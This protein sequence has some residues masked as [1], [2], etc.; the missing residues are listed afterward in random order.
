MD[1]KNIAIIFAGGSGVRMGSGMPKQFLKINGQPIIIYTLEIFDDNPEIDDI[2]IACKED[3]IGTLERYISR[4]QIQKVRKIVPGGATG[5]DSIYNAL[6]AAREDNPADSIV[7]IHDGVRPFIAQHLI[8]DNIRQVKEEG[9]AITCTPMFETP[10]KSD[11]GEIIE[12]VIKRDIMYTAQ[13]P[14]SF[15][16]GEIIEAYDEVREGDGFGGLVDSCSIF[17][18]TGHKVALV[19]GN[20]GNIKVTTPEDLYLFRGLLSYKETQ[21]AMGFAEGEIDNDLKK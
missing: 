4:Y 21:Q 11:G 6:T 15:R 7:L 14:Q 18:K 5:L 8:S 17:K 13:A 20:R 10:V 1:T 16:L 19:K 9:S 2:Y 3:C 12:D